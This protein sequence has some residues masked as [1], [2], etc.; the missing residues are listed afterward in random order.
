MNEI[1]VISSQ[2]K[3]SFSRQLLA[4]EHPGAKFIDEAEQTNRT[5]ILGVL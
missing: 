5:V 2:N 1:Y 4:Y 3:S